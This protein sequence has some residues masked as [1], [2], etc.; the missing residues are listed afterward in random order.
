MVPPTL[1]ERENLIAEAGDRQ[2]EYSRGY[3]AATWNDKEVVP[4]LLHKDMEWREQ[5]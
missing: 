5:T 3:A 1:Q 4:D 2:A